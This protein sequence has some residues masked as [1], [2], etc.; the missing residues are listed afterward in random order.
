M[1]WIRY[2]VQKKQEYI[3]NSGWQDV[4]PLVTRQGEAIGEYD[5]EEL[6][7][8]GIK[9]KAYYN[10]GTYYTVGCNSSTTLTSEETRGHVFPGYGY[11]YGI[12]TMADI[13][14]C[15]TELGRYSF[16]Q[17]SMLSGITIPSGVTLIDEDAFGFCSGLTEVTIPSNV[18]TIGNSAFIL[19]LGLSSCT[20]SNGV[21]TIG[22]YS[23]DSCRSLTSITI[24]S[25]VTSIG[26]S[27]FL[28]CWSLTSC[29][30][31]NGV[32]SIGDDA[33]R[34]CSGL[35]SVVI[36]ESVSYVGKFAF[37]DCSSLTSIT[38]NSITPPTLAGPT[39]FNNTNNC[40]IYVPCQSL[41]AYKT[42][43]NWR[44]YAS[45]ITSIT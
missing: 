12:M 43:D 17:C 36:P 9:F 16:Y 25:S 7:Y 35:T 34:G 1:T 28:D 26:S 27:A 32:T 13:G 37:N 6:C 44:N 21:E 15:V 22:N 33:F 18:T 8:G 4:T 23:F 40:P 3:A 19:C 42:A 14:D 41:N 5:T 2:K 31:N 24:P 38:F 10:D 30:I 39:V 11:K 45:R 20:I 29:T